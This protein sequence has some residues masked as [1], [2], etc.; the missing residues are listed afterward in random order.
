MHV[1]VRAQGSMSAMSDQNFMIEYIQ[2]D[3]QDESY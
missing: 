2:F 3:M 1:R